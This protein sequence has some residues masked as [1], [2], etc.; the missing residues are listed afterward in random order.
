[1][2][3]YTEIIE[4]INDEVESAEEGDGKELGIFNVGPV[5]ANV[6]RTIRG[7]VRD[8]FSGDTGLT[9]AN[10]VAAEE[11]L[12]VQVT[13]LDDVQVDDFNAAEAAEHQIFKH[14]TSNATG[15]H[16]EDSNRGWVP[17]PSGTCHSGIKKEYVF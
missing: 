16:H 12:S 3:R 4:G 13:Q 14:L 2:C 7:H 1:M 10:V 6:Q 8:G 17:F 5:W 9:L 11:E 15:P